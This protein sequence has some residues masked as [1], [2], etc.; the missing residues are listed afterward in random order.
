MLAG[1]KPENIP[2]LRLL[3]YLLQGALFGRHLP[4]LG[5]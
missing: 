4:F 1:G 3:K 5:L 2:G